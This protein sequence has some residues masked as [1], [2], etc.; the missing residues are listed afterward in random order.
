MKVKIK[1]KFVEDFFPVITENYIIAGGIEKKNE[2]YDGNEK[3]LKIVSDNFEIEMR[4]GVGHEWTKFSEDCVFVFHDDKKEIY[5]VFDGVS[6]NQDGS[7]GIASRMAAKILLNYVQTL[8]F[9]K[10]KIECIEKIKRGATTA[11]ILVVQN[12][13]CKLYNKGDCICLLNG[14]QVN[15]THNIGSML[16]AW[17][18]M[19]KEFDFYEFKKEGEVALCSD[20]IDN[21]FDDFSIIRIIFNI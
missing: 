18:N 20:G 19:E 2:D 11:L 5:A 21:P 12:N 7:G 3:F 14:K 9:E 17:L 1:G 16:Y 10:Y 13:Y 6:G 8:D 15:R 4:K